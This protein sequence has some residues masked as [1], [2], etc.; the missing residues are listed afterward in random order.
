M[1]D[2]GG[3]YTTSGDI[4]LTVTDW[5]LIDLYDSTKNYVPIL[6]GTNFK[7]GRHEDQAHFNPLGRKFPVVLRGMIRG[8]VLTLPFEAISQSDF[9]KF[10]A[11]RAGQR[12]LLLKRGYTSEQWYVSLGP[13]RSVDEAGYDATFRRWTVEATEVDVP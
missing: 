4:T 7:R 13:E 10:E 2:I 11:I 5:W 6:Y 9:D 12:T 3:T 1:P 8:E